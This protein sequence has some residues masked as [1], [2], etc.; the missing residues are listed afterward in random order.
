MISM[1]Y[2]VSALLLAMSAPG[3]GEKIERVEEIIAKVNGDIITKTEIERSRTQLRAEI[4]QAKNR[5]PDVEAAFQQREKDILRDKIDQLL[6]IQKGKEIGIN[7]DQEVSKQLNDIKL[8]YKITDDEKLADLVRQQTGMS[9]ED[10]KNEMKNSFLTQRVIRQEVG[11]RV[12]VP[13]QEVIDYYEKHKAEFVRE[14]MVFLQEI[15][16]STQGKDEAGIAAAEKKANDLVA[17]ARKGERFGDLARDNSDADSAANFGDI[18]GFKRGM[19]KKDLEDILFAQERNYVTDPIRMENGFLILKI[20]ERHRP[21]QASL[22]EVEN[23]IME[24]LFMPRFQPKIR[25]YLTQLRQDAFLEIK[26]GYVDTAAAPGKDTTWSDPAELKPETVTRAE[27]ATQT[28]RK[29]LLWLVPIPG[30]TAAP[31]SRSK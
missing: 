12:N 20:V 6:L 24:R 7:V 8:T 17:R 14:D 1:K 29:R 13:R 2:C 9:L 28:R 25:E 19:L 10:Y 18:G 21:G 5:V 26:P 15:L 30:T 16:I 11:S 4:Q 27:V 22:E 3:F 31:R 23:E